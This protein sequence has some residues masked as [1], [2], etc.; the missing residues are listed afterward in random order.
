MR[1]KVVDRVLAAFSGLIVLVIGIGL[2]VFGSGVFPFRLDVSFLEQTYGFWQRAAMVVVAVAL[3]AVGLRSFSLLFRS[4]KEKGFIAQHTEYGDLSIS[5]SAMENMVKKCVDAHEELKVSATRIHH[6]RD[7]VVVSIRISLGNGV[8]IPLTVSAL[9]KQIKQYITSCSG[10]DVKEVRVMV[11]TN[12]SLPS[13]TCPKTTDDT[14]HAD[15]DAAVKA[16]ELVEG[17]RN[18]AQ[19]TATQAPEAA[20]PDARK[21][22]HQRLFRH[23]DK[24]QTLPPPPAEAATEP[25]GPQTEAAAGEP[26]AIAPAAEPEKPVDSAEETAGGVETDKKNGED[27]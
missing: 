14:L 18:A 3:C 11:E 2:F 12:N 15:T 9:Q 1:F 17:L 8:N 24:P 19:A 5:M 21:P 20:E 23:E 6:S 10:V 26:E 16:G 25:K 4:G 13:A 27:A 22:L 7:G